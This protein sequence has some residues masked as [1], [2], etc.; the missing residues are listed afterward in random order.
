MTSPSVGKE[1]AMKTTLKALA[2]ATS[3]ALLIPSAFADESIGVVMISKGII[4]DTPEEVME[5]I[6]YLNGVGSNPAG[7][8]ALRGVAQAEVVLTDVYE[9]G[10]KGYALATYNFVNPTPWGN[11][12]QYGFWGAP[13]P[14]NATPAGLDA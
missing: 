7:C 9:Y 6:A 1:P 13:V 11:P 8:G 12:V 2:L 10:D 4:C 14:L 3:T 5:A